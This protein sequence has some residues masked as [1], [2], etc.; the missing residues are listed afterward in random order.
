M[1]LLKIQKT[2]IF[3]SEGGN[4]LIDI[5]RSN[6][7][8]LLKINFGKNVNTIENQIVFKKSLL[9]SLWM[10]GWL[11]F[12]DGGEVYL[13]KSVKIYKLRYSINF[14]KTFIAYFVADLIVLYLAFINKLGPLYMLYFLLGIMFY[15]II[16]IGFCI[17][18]E[19]SFSNL[20]IKAI[21]KSGGEKID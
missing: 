8:E 13:E 4:D 7:N 18:S 14:H 21:K 16:I 5:A 11:K 9:A 1:S 10:L 2:I 3:R 20:M 19:I 15:S 6:I 17:F 12:I